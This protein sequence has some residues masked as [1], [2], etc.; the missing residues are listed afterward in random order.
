MLK[1]VEVIKVV[2]TEL[3]RRGEGTPKSPIRR[4]EQFWSF[5]GKLLAENDPQPFL[6][7]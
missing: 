4:V 6:K 2:R 1:E 3:L 7:D 5:D